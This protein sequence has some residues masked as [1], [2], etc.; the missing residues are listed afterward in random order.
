MTV[1]LIL[2]L[3]FL[4][5]GLASFILIR[6]KQNNALPLTVKKGVMKMSKEKTLSPSTLISFVTGLVE[7]N[8]TLIYFPYLLTV[9]GFVLVLLYALL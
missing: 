4:A 2:G 9:L 6:L 7:E 8:L 1:L 5:A 3:I